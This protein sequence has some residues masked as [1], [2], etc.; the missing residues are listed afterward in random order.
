MV[1]FGAGIDTITSVG[2][3]YSVRSSRIIVKIT[4]LLLD[5]GNFLYGLIL[6]FAIVSCFAKRS[7][8][9]YSRNP[10]PEQEKCSSFCENKRN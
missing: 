5:R 2:A 6:L 3:L 1:C 4:V 8:G 10:L 9:K 7:W